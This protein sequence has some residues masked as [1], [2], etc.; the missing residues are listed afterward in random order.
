MK[1]IKKSFFIMGIIT[2]LGGILGCKAQSAKFQSMTVNDFEKCI[3][4]TSVVRLDVRTVEEYSEGHISKALNIDVL[5]SDFK[6]KAIAQLPKSKTIAVYCRSGKRS[7]RAAT[8]LSDN[9]FKVI[10]LNTGFNGWVAA[11][12][13]VTK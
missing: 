6:S 3:A 7:K 2:L 12:K 11:G 5:R 13:A 4:D 10:D 1:H 9:G 8:I